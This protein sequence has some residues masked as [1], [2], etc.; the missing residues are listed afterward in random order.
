[1]AYTKRLQE[2]IFRNFKKIKMKSI[3][4]KLLFISMATMLVW[5]CKKD[6][7]K[8]VINGGNASLSAS[9]TSLVLDSTGGG[10]AE[11]VNFT[12]PVTDYGANV[13]VKYTL[14]I[15]SVNGAFANP[16]NYNMGGELSKAFSMLDFNSISL[17]LGLEPETEGQ[18]IVRLKSDVQQ[19]SNGLGSE[20]PS[21]Y[22][23]I[24]TMNVT[25]YSTIIPPL[26]PVPD[27]LY[28]V[29]DATPGG[30]NN[31]VPVPVQELTKLDYAHF[32]AVLFLSGGK[33]YLLLPKNGEWSHKY[34][35]DGD[36][37]NVAFQTTG[38]FIP[39]GG[40]D[41][42]S[43]AA[44][45]LY[46]IMIDFLTGTYTVSPATADVPANLYL[47][48]DA[49]PGG[50]NNPVPVPQQQFTRLTNAEYTLTVDLGGPGKHYLMLP[51]NGDWG[52]KY[53]LGDDDNTKPEFR[54]GGPFR[55]DSGPDIPGP[56]EAANYTITANFI[57][58]Q[59]SL[60][61]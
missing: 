59:Y 36:N 48:G 4:N 8:A 33:H 11:A 43:P 40:A 19:I 17:S 38:P 14:Q 2:K 26:Y 53:A 16:L 10:S 9:S 27:H 41:M 57:T 18:L 25:P 50:W 31:P 6:E 32:G 30:W 13:V 15:D 49:T 55:A 56:D 60:T 24:V 23:N 45:G 35:L 46:K 12:W 34:G 47:V 3:V 22:S 28:I 20:Y 44:D 58:W 61:K 29:G 52:H 1:M 7:V 54:L 21:V 39:D 5:S 42:P 37:S 51:V